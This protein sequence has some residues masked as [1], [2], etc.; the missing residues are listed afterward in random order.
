MLLKIR[1]RFSW[2]SPFI[3]MIA[4]TAAGLFPDVSH[5]VINS[6]SSEARKREELQKYLTVLYIKAAFNGL[7]EVEVQDET[8]FDEKQLKRLLLILEKEE[9]IHSYDGRWRI[10]NPG[11][12]S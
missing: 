6:V 7:T 12:P 8:R 5:T 10:G 1:E 4:S 11:R 9:R 3:S 2:V